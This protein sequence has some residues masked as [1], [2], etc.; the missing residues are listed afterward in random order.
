MQNLAHSASFESLEKDAPGKAGIKQLAAEKEDHRKTAAQRDEAYN[1]PL[2]VWQ[3]N[4]EDATLKLFHDNPQRLEAIMRAAA[5][6]F[7]FSLMPSTSA[8]AETH[9]MAEAAGMQ[10]HCAKCGKPF[11]RTRPDK[12]HCSVGCR[13]A[14]QQ[15]NR[16]AARS[17]KGKKADKAVAM[18]ALESVKLPETW[19]SDWRE[20]AARFLAS[21]NP[22]VPPKGGRRRRL[23]C[24][25][26][27]AR[28]TLI[29]E[30]HDNKGYGH[31]L[32]AEVSG[33][34]FLAFYGD[35]RSPPLVFEVEAYLGRQ[36]C[37]LPTYEAEREAVRK[38]LKD[39]WPKDNG[40]GE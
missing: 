20:N 22:L 17:G 40:A 30:G 7:G 35:G 6:L 16:R 25:D 3:T 34:T 39:Q 8:A 24:L 12:L 11:V 37:L 9:A 18:Q 21:V 10:A 19:D 27:A 28:E 33:K 26:A 36:P 38:A 29:K 32:F 13:N 2:T 14:A 23:V 1:N 15:V 5:A 4:A 31:H